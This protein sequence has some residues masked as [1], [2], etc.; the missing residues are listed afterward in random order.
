MAGRGPCVVRPRPPPPGRRKRRGRGR[1]GRLGPATGKALQC[2]G[3]RT[4]GKGEWGREPWGGSCLSQP[5]VSGCLCPFQPER[6]VRGRG[7]RV[8]GPHIRT[9][10]GTH[11][12]DDWSFGRQCPDTTSICPNS[13]TLV[14]TPRPFRRVSFTGES[15]LNSD[16]DTR[17]FGS[18]FRPLPGASGARVTKRVRPSPARLL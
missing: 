18:L 3:V 10:R 17:H 15:R 13:Q 16:R 9:P 6:G 1:W 14:Q 5:G 8:S 11:D 12:R 7:L 2:R 4:V